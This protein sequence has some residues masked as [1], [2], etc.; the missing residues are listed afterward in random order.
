MQA[1]SKNLAK[2]KEAVTQL[3]AGSQ[4]IIQ[5]V[6]GHT[7]SG[8]AYT[9][10]K[11]LFI[12]LILPTIGKVTS[13]CDAIAQELQKY[14][15]ADPIVSSEGFLDEDNLKKQIETKKNMKLSV[16]TTASILHVLM[17]TGIADSIFDVAQNR[18]RELNRMSDDLQHDIDELQRKIDKLHEFDGQTKNLFKSS[19][20][21]LKLAMQGVMVLNATTVN[22]DGT[23]KLPAGAD[24]SWFT[25]LKSK[26]QQKAMEEKEKNALIKA[27]NDL[28]EK[29]P[30]AAIE[31][32]KNNDRLFGYVISALDKFPEKIQNAALGIFVA[33]ESWNKLPKNVAIKVL[34]SPK[35]AYYLSEASF[36]TQALVYKGLVKLSEK[37]WSVLAP[38]GYATKI[39]SKTSQGAKLIAG[40]KVGFDLFKKLGPVSEFVKNHKVA[41]ES[42]GYVGDGLSVAA[43]AYEEF[44]DPKSPAYGNPSKA[45]YGGLNLFLLNAGPLE[46]A[47]YAG[48]PGAIAGTVN[49]AIQGIEIQTPF[50]W[51][52][53]NG[54]IGWDGINGFGTDKDAKKWLNEQYEIYDQREKNLKDGNISKVKEDWFGKQKGRVDVGDFN[55]GL[56]RW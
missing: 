42:V 26:D 51:L 31:K 52:G 25:E 30:L 56:P 53:N 2:A 49:T 3:K 41:T 20:D 8:A 23:Y 22:S 11:G 36:A 9:A 7:L 47:Q 19:L 44:I 55:N 37:G 38:F 48:V 24:K 28:F 45:T 10:G 54:K 1:L 29:N 14:Q 4:K 17:K 21:E 15:A 12:D 18:K 16:D 33:Q 46:G 13:A 5:A 40:S 34:N 50:K 35:F 32:V 39:L 27:L 6:D 43:Y